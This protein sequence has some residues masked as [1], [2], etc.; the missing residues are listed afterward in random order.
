MHR[1]KPIF[2]RVWQAIQAQHFT[3]THRPSPFLPAPAA[4][5]A[6]RGRGE[7]VTGNREESYLNAREKLNVAY[8]N[9]SIVLAAI[10]GMLSQSMIV[11][12]GFLVGGV[13]TSLY[14]GNIRSS[15][16]HRPH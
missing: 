10:A 3:L 12:V 9:G 7:S 4:S 15:P 2:Q 13:L 14:L 6:R 1:T 8:L 5:L 16:R 11:F